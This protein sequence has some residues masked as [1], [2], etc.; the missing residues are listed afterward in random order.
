[1]GWCDVVVGVGEE[2]GVYWWF[3]G[4]LVHCLTEAEVL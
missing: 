1:M 4:G 2:V 3:V